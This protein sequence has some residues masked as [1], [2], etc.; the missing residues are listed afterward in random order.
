MAVS[1]EQVFIEFQTDVSQLTAAIDALARLGL[2]D[3]KVA[4][5]FKAT[6]IQLNAQAATLKQATAN[7]TPLKKGLEGDE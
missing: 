1:N 5:E 4:E 2:V 7:V 3:K 6:N